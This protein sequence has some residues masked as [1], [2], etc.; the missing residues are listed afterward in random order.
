MGSQLLNKLVGPND[1]VKTK[2]EIANNLKILKNNSENFRLSNGFKTLEQ[3][4]GSEKVNILLKDKSILDQ[5]TKSYREQT[6]PY[7]E[8]KKLMQAQ[9]SERLKDTQHL[10]EKVA[11]T[12][13][14]IKQSRLSKKLEQKKRQELKM[15][16]DEANRKKQEEQQELLK[17]KKLDEI[18]ERRK[19]FEEEREKQALQMKEYQKKFIR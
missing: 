17:K 1:T 4:L 6:P 15:K 16:I 13:Q 3:T 8:R 19:K 10:I 5:Q 2:I 14:D 9:L 18:E 7:T 11:K 12:R